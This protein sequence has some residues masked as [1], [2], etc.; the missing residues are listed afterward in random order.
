VIVVVKGLGGAFLKT[1][2]IC[3]R[4]RVVRYLEVETIRVKRDR[5]GWARPPI[6]A[7]C[8]IFSIL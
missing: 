2:S 1:L 8:R 7:H 4:G 5:D 6:S 3:F